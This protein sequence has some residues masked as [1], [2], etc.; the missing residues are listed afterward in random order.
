MS[1]TFDFQALGQWPHQAISQQAFIERLKTALEQAVE[2]FDEQSP[3]VVTLE[4]PFAPVQA[5]WESGWILQSGLDLPILPSARLLWWKSDTAEFGG[6]YG[7]IEGDATVYRRENLYPAGSVIAIESDVAPLVSTTMDWQIGD[8]LHYTDLPVVTF[9][10]P[11]ACDL[12]VIVSMQADLASGTG[13]WGVDL[14]VDGVKQGS[15]DFAISSIYGLRGV[16]DTGE[17]NMHYPINNVAAGDHTIRL[18]AGYTGTP[19]TPPTFTIAPNNSAFPLLVV[20]A[21]AQ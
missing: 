2:Y 19:S 8:A 18:L 11:V 16:T 15:A 5:E 12:E 4:Q 14:L 1:R 10:L 20:K 13:E 21:Y 9:T 7:T 17:I 6:E 3:K